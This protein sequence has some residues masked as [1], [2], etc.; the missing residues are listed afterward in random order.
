[1]LLAED[2]VRVIDFGIVRAVGDQTRI[3]HA[4]SLIGSPAYMSPEQVLG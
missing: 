4:G 1:M 3:A 2:G